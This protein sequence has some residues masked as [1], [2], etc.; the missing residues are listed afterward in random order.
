MQI[1]VLKNKMEKNLL[2]MSFAYF[3]NH[4]LKAALFY[5]FYTPYIL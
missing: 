5:G 1:Q 3:Y 4:I 2:T